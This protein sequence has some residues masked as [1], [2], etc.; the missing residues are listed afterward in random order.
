MPGVTSNSSDSTLSIVPHSS[1]SETPRV[2]PLRHHGLTP[3]L[4]RVSISWAR[5]NTLRVSLIQSEAV[6]GQ[7]TGGEVVEVKLT[8]MKGGEITAAQWRRIAYGSVTPFALLQSRKNSMDS[9]HY[10]KDW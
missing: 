1:D 3:P 4:A 2:Y 6:S 9:S 8:N 5:G 10:S 7:Q